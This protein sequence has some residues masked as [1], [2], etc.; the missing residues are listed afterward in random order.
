MA[1]P[2]AHEPDASPPASPAAADR[3]PWLLFLR[4]KRVIVATTASVFALSL[5]AAF[6]VTPI[7]RVQAVLIRAESASAS[8]AM[9]ALGDLGGL[10]SLAGVS[11]GGSNDQSIE[12]IALLKS[13]QFAL[14]F[15]DDWHLM[16]ILFA[17]KWDPSKDRWK[18]SER[19]V[20]TQ[21]DAYELFDRKIRTVTEDKKT[22]LVTLTI[23]WKDPK[24]A[25]A[26]ATELV[27]RVND[28][29]RARAIAESQ[30]TI[31]QLEQELAKSTVI[32]LQQSLSGALEMQIK[33]RALATARPD[34]AFRVIDPPFVPDEKDFVYPRRMLFAALGLLGGLLAGI[35]AAYVCDTIRPSRP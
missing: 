14:D 29:M 25:A 28:K 24:V 2:M 12:S 31:E 9:R 8:G 11:L 15:I 13:R 34:F 10:A 3:D 22:S 19:S 17:R 33:R 30:V 6:V 4:W 1:A 27:R 23:E 32:P 18:V 5:V 35:V 7:Y 16:P 26:W 20:P 21:D